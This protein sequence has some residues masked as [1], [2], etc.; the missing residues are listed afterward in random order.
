LA[1]VYEGERVAGPATPGAT[2]RQRSRKLI[3]VA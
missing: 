3:P 1:G 2:K